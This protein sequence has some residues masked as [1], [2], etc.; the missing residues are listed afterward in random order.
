MIA[1]PP[2]IA[3]TPDHPVLAPLLLRLVVVPLDGEIHADAQDD[4]LEREEDVGEPI[5]HV[6]NSPV[7]R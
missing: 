4:D 6:E 5:P 1:T 2:R 3:G 7:L